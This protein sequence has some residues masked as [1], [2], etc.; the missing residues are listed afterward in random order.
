[1]LAQAEREARGLGHPFVGTEHLLLGML[2]TRPQSAGDVAS[3]SVSGADVAPRLSSAAGSA[4][5]ESGPGAFAMLAAAGVRYDDARVDVVRLGTRGEGL[6]PADADALQAI[7][8][9]IEAVRA[10]VEEMFGVGALN[11][12]TP[13]PRPGLLG[14]FRR[15]RAPVGPSGRRLFTARMRRIF[16]FCVRE[17]ERREDRQISTELLLLGIVREGRGLA[18]RVLAGR[19]VDVADLGARIESVL[20]PRR[21]RHGA[22]PVGP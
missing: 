18:S 8:I 9:D 2:A 11:P 5:P 15:R 7:G 13:R 14:F 12:P 22:S 16:V 3:G 21:E 20:P 6:G 10:R 1:V 19:G 4:S 17:A